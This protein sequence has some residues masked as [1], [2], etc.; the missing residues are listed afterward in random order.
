MSWLLSAL[1]L[2]AR[3]AAQN[4][5]S[6]IGPQ[7]IRVPAS[8]F[9]ASS[10]PIISGRVTAIAVN[11]QNNDVV[12]LGAAS[13]GIWKSTDG[14]AS[15]TPLTDFQPSLATGSL[16]IDPSSCT[17]DD[18]TTI[19]VGTGEVYGS[20]IYFGAGILKSTDAGA[21]WT[22]QGANIFVPQGS[23]D[24]AARIGAI[25]VDP[26][27]SQIAL[28]GTSGGLY[29]TTDGGATW[30]Q[31]AALS[32]QG[33]GLS[34]DVNNSGVVYAALSQ[35]TAAGIYRS[36][37]HGVTWSR[38]SGTGVNL[39]PTTGVGYMALSVVSGAAG[40]VGGVTLYAVVQQLNSNSLR[41]VWKSSDSGAN[42]V[43]LVNTPNFCFPLCGFATAIAADPA[44]PDIV[45]AGGTLDAFAKEFIRSADGGNTWVQVGCQHPSAGSCT[46]GDND[47]SVGTDYHALVFTAD[48]SRVYMGN[49]Q[50]AWRTDNPE[51]ADPTQLHYLDLNS[52][53]AITQQYGG[54]AI[55]PSYENV[56]FV[57]AQ[58]VGTARYSGGM[59][60]GKVFSEGDG[61][62][63]AIDQQIPSVVYTT[64]MGSC[65]GL[66][67]ARSFF[68]GTSISTFLQST[69]NGIADERTHF[70]APLTVDPNITGRV[71]YGTFRVYLT[72]DYAETWT[73]ISPD[74]TGGGALTAIAVA[75]SDSNVV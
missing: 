50:G 65:V 74:L 10:G 13:G 23:P 58:D 35:A 61:G 56:G 30:T 55:S 62:Q 17:A 67:I 25:A 24:R 42:W 71:Y 75:P 52:V 6:P 39:F 72:I 32:G 38:L 63:A 51:V 16:A 21:T 31:V 37:D 12:Y 69:T 27:N 40:A 29:R 4:S 28:A 57:G 47:V 73:P 64:S 44:N 36:T 14:G 66:C 45:F 15:W 18:C 59:A 11:P 20:S 34:F 53:L 41:G 60:W 2:A 8:P 9:L 49:D 7:P 22:Q 26:F 46:L 48:G 1:W 33:T 70:P 68:D 54:H 3:G 43:Q 19:Y 5:W